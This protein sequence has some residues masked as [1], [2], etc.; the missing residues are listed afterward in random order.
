MKT[1][2]E[3]ITKLAS[4]TQLHI[5]KTYL[6]FADKIVGF[7]PVEGDVTRIRLHYIFKGKEFTTQYKTR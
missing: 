4:S 7:T 5:K 1:K 3:P 6:D 2:I